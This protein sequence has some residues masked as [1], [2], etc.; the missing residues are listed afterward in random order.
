MRSVQEQAVQ[1][2]A[3]R[4]VTLARAALLGLAAHV[5]KGVEV[6]PEQM[7]AIYDALA[8]PLELLTPRA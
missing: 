7:L 3:L 1:E 2:K 6:T 4:D 5:G 8:L